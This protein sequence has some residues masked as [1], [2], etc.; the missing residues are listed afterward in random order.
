M[1]KKNLE[2]KNKGKLIIATRD[3]YDLHD[4]LKLLFFFCFFSFVFLP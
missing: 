3:Q 2:K 1:V 4:H